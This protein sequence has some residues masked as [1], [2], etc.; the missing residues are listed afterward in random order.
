MKIK[1]WL[2]MPFI[3]MMALTTYFFYCVPA[4]ILFIVRLI[5]YPEKRLSTILSVV[6]IFVLL[7]VASTTM[8]DSETEDTENLE[9]EKSTDDLEDSSSFIT[10]SENDK[11]E[12]NTYDNDDEPVEIVK[13]FLD[14]HISEDEQTAISLIY[15]DYKEEASYRLEEIDFESARKK[16]T[17]MLMDRMV[18]MAQNLFDST[19]H[20]ID[21]NYLREDKDFQNE[22]KDTV[23]YIYQEII[24]YEILNWSELSEGTAVVTVNIVAKDVQLENTLKDIASG[25]IWSSVMEKL[26]SNSN[27]VNGMIAKKIVKEKLID[28]M[29]EVKERISQNEEKSS[30]GT[31]TFH[32]MNETGSWL[33][34]RFESDEELQNDNE[35]R[36][37]SE[38]EYFEDDKESMGQNDEEYLDDGE[39]SLYDE[40]VENDYPDSLSE[41]YIVNGSDD[42]YFDQSYFEEL[43][44]DELRLARNEIL[45][46][47]GRM[48]KDQQL[49]DYFNSKSWYEPQYS[50]D[51]FDLMMEEILNQ[52]EKANIEIIK[53]V[54]ASRE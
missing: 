10:D 35:E 14:A 36:V 39:E 53:Q 25:V 34:Y 17:S 15:D 8:L 45:A 11:L 19:N 32:L 52:W 49:Q 5:K 16:N 44:D 43:T 21:A 29:K 46:R 26:A 41:E 6:G 28:T 22:V 1:W 42:K 33:I 31:L 18:M 9:T 37:Y 54:E 48:F 24:K 4:I 40:V 7:L 38:D 20:N 23:D 2:S 13:R 27:F 47:H 30:M 3:C 50:P 12:D 51:E